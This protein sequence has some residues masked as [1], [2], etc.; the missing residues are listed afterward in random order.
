V[1]EVQGEAAYGRTQWRRFA[2]LVGVPAVI[3][4]GIVV[5]VAQGALAASFTVSGSTFKISADRLDG[6]GFAQY[7]GLDKQEGNP[8]GVPV[9]VSGIKHAELTNLCQ[10]VKVAG[11]ISLVIRAGRDSKN[12]AVADN[13][14]IDMSELSG[15]ATFT[16]INIGQD[17]GT[18]TAAGASA[19]GAGGQFGQQADKV[20]IT[21]LT[22][23]AWAT[24]AGTFKLTG[25]NMKVNT[26]E[27]GKAVECF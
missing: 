15:D 18:L 13:L 10:S 27:N 22:Q 2:V 4:G 7:G 16:N 23:T 6:D 17:A 5:G 21:G 20:V 9:A 3:A 11:P 19:H 12:P 1:Q 24:S 14:L 8:T 26:G 25:L